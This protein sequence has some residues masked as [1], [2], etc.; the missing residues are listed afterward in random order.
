MISDVS[1]TAM[2]TAFQRA[3]ENKRDDRLFHDPLSEVFWKVGQ[4]VLEERR[5]HRIPVDSK[6]NYASIADSLQN[7]AALRTRFL[8]DLVH[9]AMD[10]GCQQVVILGAGLDCRPY[11]LDFK[12]DCE[13][14]EIDL[15]GILEFK[16]S[17]LAERK[18]KPVCPRKCVFSDVTHDWRAQLIE[19]GFAR[20]RPTVW[21][22]E[23]I[24]PYLKPDDIAKLLANIQDMSSSGSRCGFDDGQELYR[25]FAEAC[26]IHEFGGII[27]FN[28]PEI[29]GDELQRRGWTL[30]SSLCSELASDYG[31]TDMEAIGRMC[32]AS[33]A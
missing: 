13:I 1:L 24:L 17:V 26:N 6:L 4:D 16:E 5:Q 29:V 7:F 23:G 3:Q 32:V 21:L 33:L 18:V 12:N 20:E 8:D 25:S 19:A 31:R 14:F 10:G 2:G 22:M 15:P 9:D 11:R 27:S 28:S 30:T